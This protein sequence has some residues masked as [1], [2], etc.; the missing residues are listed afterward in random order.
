MRK[1]PSACLTAP[2]VVWRIK[3]TG[4]SFVLSILAF[5]GSKSLI[6]FFKAFFGDVG[7]FTTTMGMEG[8]GGPVTL[9]VIGYFLFLL[10]ALFIVIA[11]FMVLIR[12]KNSKTK[13]TIVFD[14]LSVAASVAAVICFTV[15]G[16]R[17]A[18]LGAF[19]FGGNAALAPSGSI[20]WGYFVAL[21]LLLV[22][23]GMNIAVVKA[24]AK[25]DEQLENERLARVAAKEEKERLAEEKRELERVQALFL[26]LCRSYGAVD[27]VGCDLKARGRL[28][29]VVVVAHPAD[30]GRLYIREHFTVI[31]H[32]HLRLAVLTL[33]CATDMTAQQMHHQLAAITDAQ[34]RHTPCKDLRVDRGRILQ[35]NAVGATG[36]DDALGILC[37]DDRQIGFIGIDLT[38]DIVLA[39]TARDQ[40]IVLAAKIQHDNSFMLHDILSSL[41]HSMCFYR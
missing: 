31:V 35:I 9:G 33:R 8:Y 10:S 19:S 34:H 30:G 22:A 26:V 11:F 18:D 24:P 23:T 14:V 40:L 20:G 39:D 25:S 36:E 37:L 4:S 41:I 5:D 27:R 6:D 32:E 2:S 7:L 3:G 12:C 28:L 29:N 38:V 1:K 17:G 16:Q 21:L 13:T 15:G